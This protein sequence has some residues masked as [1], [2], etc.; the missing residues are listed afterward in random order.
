VR[1]TGDSRRWI[2]LTCE[3]ENGAVSQASLS[4]AVRLTRARTRIELY[5]EEDE[6]V[7]DAA[8]FDHEECWPVLRREFAEAVRG[9]RTPDPDARRGLRLQELLEQVRAAAV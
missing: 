6:L 5:G 4:G 3:H 7:Y 8:E 9:R 1:G 2:E